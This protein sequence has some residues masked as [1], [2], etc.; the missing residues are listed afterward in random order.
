[1]Q[2]IAYGFSEV[3]L[4][5]PTSS[6]S[7]EHAGSDTCIVA[8]WRRRNFEDRVLYLCPTR[9]LAYQ[10]LAHAE[11]RYGIDLANLIGSKTGY[12]ENEKTAYIT[13]QKVAVSTYSAL[14]NSNPYF[15]NPDVIILDDAHASENYVARMWSLEIVPGESTIGRLHNS[16]CEYLQPYID[17]SSYSKLTGT[18]GDPLDSTWV[19]KLPTPLF[20]S[21]STEIA[22]IISAYAEACSDI[23]FQWQMIRDNLNACHLYLSSRSILIRPLISP[24]WSHEPFETA[25]QRI[26]MSA[27]LGEGGDLERLVGRSKIHRVSGPVGFD[28]NG[29]GRRFFIFPGLSL[30]DHEQKALRVALQTKAGRSVILTPSKRGADA[31]VE[32]LEAVN[33]LSIFT[34]QDIETSKIDFIDSDNATAILA[35]RFDG[36]DFPG[37]ECRL[38]CLDGLP[39]AG[40]LQEKFLML[41]M[42]A[43]ALF[44]ERIRTRVFQATGRCTRALQDRS[45]V[46]VTGHE[47]VQYLCDSR[48]WRFFHPELQAELSF[49][50]HQSSDV[51]FD[52][53]ESNFSDFLDNTDA[54]EG[55]NEEILNSVSEFAAES[56]PSMVELAEVV[57]HEIRFQKLLWEGNFKDSLVEAKKV[58]P[59]LN[60]SDLRGYRALWHYLAGSAA[61]MLELAGDSSMASV[62]RTQFEAASRSAPAVTWLSTLA[63]SD[64][65]DRE[66]SQTEG[67]SPIEVAAIQ[68]D[69]ARG[70]HFSDS[71]RLVRQILKGHCE[72]R[73]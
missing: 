57:Q 41:R 49:G 66:G 59:K 50:V 53:L 22:E 44:N 62:A 68:V 51:T 45:A 7:G 67:G 20:H 65:H 16:L 27:T 46:Y 42:G 69:A 14:F 39:N 21:L 33:G 13:G 60:A 25:Q 23:R 30:A 38:L 71:A 5:R 17:H 72:S 15:T 56:Y 47:L 9:Q 55:A 19:D 11:E 58:I 32:E 63:I 34:A 24:T 10:A 28:A 37:D 18:W 2:T 12:G 36:V 8:E 26:Y 29:V 35:N 61:K 73:A 4:Q 6:G 40:N 3:A 54:W 52:D 70:K 43:R 48:N 31:L 64:Q 1:M